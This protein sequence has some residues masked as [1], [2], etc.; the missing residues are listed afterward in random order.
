MLTLLILLSLLVLLYEQNIGDLT[1]SIVVAATVTAASKNEREVLSGSVAEEQERDCIRYDVRQKAIRVSCKTPTHL[2]DIYNKLGL[3]NILAKEEPLQRQAVWILNTNLSI[4]NGSTLII[5]S[6]DTKWLK[7]VADGKTENSIEVFGSLKIDSVKITSWDPA[8]N[9]YAIDYGTRELYLNKSGSGIPRPFILVRAAATGT[10]D[11]TNS[12]LAYL[13]YKCIGGNCSGI[14]YFGGNDSIIKGNNIHNNGF[15]FYSNGVANIIY[16][17]NNVHHNSMYGIDPHTAAHDMIIRNNTVHDNGSIGIACALD[18][19]NVTIEN[20]VVYNNTRAGIL[21]STNMYNS[22]A[23]NNII[24]NETTG[25]SV[26][27]S[28]NNEIYNNTISNVKNGIKLSNMSS[29]NII[30]NN[31]IKKATGLGIE[32]RPSAFGNTF[33]S[34]ILINA[35]ENEAITTPIPNGSLTSENSNIRKNNDNMSSHLK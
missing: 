27:N 23:R 17:D 7:I 11:I 19:Y 31:L 12:E 3:D 25:I 18:C 4:D 10:T 9:N 16:E 13:G 21:F 15:G 20:N 14:R 32:V 8:K 34:N 24:S 33:Y 6:N 5:D 2:T 30:G 35:T 26:F 29:H 28:H 1:H 22:T